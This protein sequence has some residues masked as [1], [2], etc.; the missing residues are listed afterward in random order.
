LDRSPGQGRRGRAGR[1]GRWGRDRDRAALRA[2]GG[3]WPEPSRRFNTGNALDQ[4]REVFPVVEETIL[5]VAL[6][7]TELG[8]IVDYVITQ[9]V[10]H[11]AADESK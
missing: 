3:A 8:P 1:T 4:L 7:F 9:S 10:P 11:Q 6:V 5:P 2:G